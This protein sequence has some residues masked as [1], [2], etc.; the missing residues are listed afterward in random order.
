MAKAFPKRNY[1]ARPKRGERGRPVSAA[2]APAA[3]TAWEAQATWY[4][5]RHGD[6]GDDFHSRVILPAVLQRLA[7]KPGER[8]LDVCCGP[9][10][11]GRALAATG[12]DSV[13][14]D[15]SPTLIESAQARA[16]KREL[17]LVGDCRDLP[18]VLA[19]G[20]IAGT[21]NHAALVMALQDLDPMPPVLAGCATALKPGGRAVLALT[22]PCFRIPRRSSWGWDE[23]NGLQYRRIDG[24]LSPLAAPI[25]THPGRPKDAS[26]TTSFHRPLSA[27]INACGAAGLAIVA[28][29]ELCSHRR[30]TK[31]PRFGAEDRAAKEFPVFLVLTAVRT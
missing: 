25:K 11:L 17:Y 28:A 22:H 16:G 31:G 12:V 1:V 7:A 15:A 3:P 29:D 5:Q 4:D 19:V 6:E 13:G 10:L 23:A 30:G 21:F 24:Y 9:G 26:Q 8:V 2:V 20:G 18:A 14:V 27:Y